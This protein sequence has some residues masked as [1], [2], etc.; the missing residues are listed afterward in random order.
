MNAVIQWL[1]W[2]PKGWLANRPRGLEY[3]TLG[4]RQQI[5]SREPLASKKSSHTQKKKTPKNRFTQA[6]NRG[7]WARAESPY[8][9]PSTG[10]IL[11]A[12]AFCSCREQRGALGSLARASRGGCLLSPSRTPAPGTS[13]ESLPAQCALQGKKRSD[14]FFQRGRSLGSSM[15]S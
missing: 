14:N 3:C 8:E 11:Q 7:G 4:Q 6:L 1:V 15:V 12:D 9:K 13:S 5:K 10:L 2:G